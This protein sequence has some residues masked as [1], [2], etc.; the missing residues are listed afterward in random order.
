VTALSKYVRKPLSRFGREIVARAR[1]LLLQDKHLDPD[2]R[3][4]FRWKKLPIGRCFIVGRLFDTLKN[5]V[6]TSSV[7]L[8]P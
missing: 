3:G 5:R 8:A 2:D 7:I 4:D 6:V 1:N